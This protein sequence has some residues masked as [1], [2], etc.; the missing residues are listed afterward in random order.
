MYS[1]SLIQTKGWFDH[2]WCAAPATLEAAKSARAAEA[3][4]LCVDPEVLPLDV[5]GARERLSVAL[6]AL[7]RSGV[8]DQS[9]PPPSP[10]ELAQLAV[11]LLE[12]LRPFARG[13]A[14]AISISVHPEGLMLAGDPGEFIG[15]PTSERLPVVQLTYL[16]PAAGEDAAFV[17]SRGGG[18]FL[19]PGLGAAASCHV[20]NLYGARDQVRAALTQPRWVAGAR[21]GVGAVAQLQGWVGGMLGQKSRSARAAILSSGIGVGVG[22]DAI[23]AFNVGLYLLR[24]R[25]LHQFDLD[26]NHPKVR[27]LEHMLGRNV[28]G[29]EKAPS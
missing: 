3:K 9:A 29:S 20:R 23:P 15:R 26:A 5:L 19:T 22:V 7:R 14:T 1:A 11:V 6:A 21:G 13:D 16:R 25:P 12:A 17:I 18:L 2:H 4:D 8:L 27:R 10:D 28:D 24:E